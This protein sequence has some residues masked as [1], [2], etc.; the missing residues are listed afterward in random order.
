M[1]C[2][3]CPRSCHADR[4]KGETGFCG[5]GRHA[6]LAKIIDGFTYEEPCLGTVDA[7]FF[8]GCSLKC[9]YCQNYKIS[10]G[11]A[12]EE[13]GDKEL[14]GVFDGRKNPIDLVT[15]SHYLS[16]IERAVELCAHAHSFIY[17][18][19]GYET[20]AAVERAAAFTSVF[21][22]DY[23]YGDGGV[24]QKLSGAG[25]YR[26]VAKKALYA[27]RSISDAWTEEG[28]EKRLKRGLIVRHLVLPGY[29]DNSIKALDDIAEI[30]GTDT[31]LSLMSQFTPNGAGEPS[32]RLKKIEYKLVVEHALKLG[33]NVGY[34]QEFDSA[35]DIYIP[36][37]R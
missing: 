34:L 26:E 2:V 6:R 13:L 32:A 31:L 10:R 29:V 35:S 9:S 22:T 20:T 24:A 5:G 30:V 25:D 19:S 33:F 15:P 37:F 27:M 18:T 14:A 17:N 23:K 12:G 4:E 3:D 1:K 21:L 7:L 28:G 16:N 36:D 8:S 11:G